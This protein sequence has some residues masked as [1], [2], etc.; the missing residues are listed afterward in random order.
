[1]KAESKLVTYLNKNYIDPRSKLP[2][3]IVRLE[4]AMENAKIRIDP[5]GSAIKQAEAL[6]K[7]LEGNLTFVKSEMEATLTIDTQYLGQVSNTVHAMAS[8]K[9]EEYTATGVIWELGI[10]P[11]GELS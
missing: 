7:S 6:I 10:P 1:L 11:G 9:R 5:D 4:Q 2:H 3:P 8:I